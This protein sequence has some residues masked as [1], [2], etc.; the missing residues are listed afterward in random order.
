M[1]SHA[2]VVN[3]GRMEGVTGDRG[4]RKRNHVDQRKNTRERGEVAF[5]VN[6][7][8][9]GVCYQGEE[10]GRKWGFPLGGERMKSC[11]SV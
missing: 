7:A 3:I 11:A 1:I 2:H 5:T 8:V 6:E 9:L 4:G 10:E